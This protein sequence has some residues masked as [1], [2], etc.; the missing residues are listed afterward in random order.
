MSEIPD[1]PASSS[2]DVPQFPGSSGPEAPEVPELPDVPDV[3]ENPL[4]NTGE[5]TQVGSNGGWGGALFGAGKYEAA[6]YKQVMV[7]QEVYPGDPVGVRLQA[8]GVNGDTRVRELRDIM[9]SSF[10]LVS[11]ARVTVGEEGENPTIL[12]EGQYEVV[13]REDGFREIRVPFGTNDFDRPTL[14]PGQTLTVDIVYRAPQE[15]GV[16]EHGGYARTVQWG[17]GGAAELGGQTGGQPIEVKER[18][19]VPEVP[20]LPGDESGDGIWGSIDW[21]SFDLGALF[22]SASGNDEP[23]EEPVDEGDAAADPAE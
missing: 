11:V 23:T 16:Y 18:P 12:E 14:A 5:R 9:P 1:A 10:E 19:I 20:E 6:F 17:G 22:G 4:I 3:P 8:E 21:G 7:G 2:A 15:V 13:E